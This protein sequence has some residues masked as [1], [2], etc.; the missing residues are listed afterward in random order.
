MP[1][2]EP[3][4]RKETVYLACPYRDA[5][6][7]VRAKRFMAATAAAASLA[8]HG[9]VVY[10]PVTMSHVM[11]TALV[12]GTVL[13]SD[14]WVRFDEGVMALCTEMIVVQID[15]W[16]RSADIKRNVDYFT[17]QGKPIKFMDAPLTRDRPA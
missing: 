12:A 11:E 3:G 5:D 8:R 2:S 6:R 13:D 4:K 1:S 17:R 14:E 7:A 16:D 15:G 9:F 10:S